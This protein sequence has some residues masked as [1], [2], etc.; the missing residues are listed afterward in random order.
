MNKRVVAIVQARMG[1]TRL[2]GKVLK[3]ILGK[4]LVEY[5]I[6]RINS[7]QMINDLVIATTTNRCDDAIVDYCRTHHIKYYRGSEEDVLSRYMEAAESYK[8]E[9]IVRICS[10]SPL[11]DPLLIDELVREF[12]L[13]YPSCDYLSNT[14]KQTYPLGMNIE[15]FSFESLQK[16]YKNA[17]SQYE[18]EHVT[19]YIYYNPHQFKICEKHYQHDLSMLRLTVDVAEDF[20]LVKTILEKLYPIDPCFTLENIVS[21]YNQDSD[22]FKIN[23]HILQ[24]QVDP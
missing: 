5:L 18:K 23:S 16:T 11:V 1:S 24:K 2:P 19:P 20:E 15:V 9:V 12:L 6:E 14:I 21:L 22:I 17:K 4:P 8:A 3:K 7:S 13:K 10:D